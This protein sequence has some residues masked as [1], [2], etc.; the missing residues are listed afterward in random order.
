MILVY[1]TFPAKNE[2]E[3][4]AQLLIERKLIACANIFPINSMYKWE[5]K[6]MKEKE[7]VLIGKTINKKY[8]DIIKIIEMRHSYETPCVIKINAKAN[9]KY[10]KWVKSIL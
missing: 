9:K 2:C 4:T 1:I 6:L 3:K 5:N 7:F 10:D 8:K